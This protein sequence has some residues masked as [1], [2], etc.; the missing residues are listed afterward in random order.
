MP[1]SG[2]HEKKDCFMYAEQTHK[3][4]TSKQTHQNKRIALAVDHKSDLWYT[5]RYSTCV[6]R[7]SSQKQHEEKRLM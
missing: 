7:Q 4:N 2:C 5:I 6:Y 1:R 3:T